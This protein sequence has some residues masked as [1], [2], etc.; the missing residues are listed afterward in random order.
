MDWL[1]RAYD[2]GFRFVRWPP[3]DPAF[4]DFRGNPR[5]LGVM[6][7]MEADI[8]RMRTRLFEVDPALR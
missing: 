2:A 1:E 3:V 8:E 5:Y 4:D 6:A 7:K